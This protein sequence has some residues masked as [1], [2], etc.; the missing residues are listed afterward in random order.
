LWH[1]VTS[2]TG[3]NVNDASIPFRTSVEASDEE[4]NFHLHGC[5]FVKKGYPNV[6][7]LSGGWKAWEAAGYPVDPK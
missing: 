4:S 1:A 3:F 7:T 2:T 6:C 5:V